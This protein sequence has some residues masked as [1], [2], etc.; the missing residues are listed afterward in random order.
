MINTTLRTLGLLLMGAAIVMATPPRDAHACDPEVIEEGWTLVN[1]FPADGDDAAPINGVVTARL[2]FA[3]HSLRWPNE[4]QEPNSLEMVLLRGADELVEGQVELRAD[5]KEARFI[6]ERPLAEGVSYTLRLTLKNSEVGARGP[7]Q[8]V[9]VSFTTGNLFDESPPAFSGIQSMRLTQ[10]DSPIKECCEGRERYCEGTCSNPCQWCWIAGWNYLP[11]VQLDFNAGEDEFGAQTVV[12]TVHRLDGPDAELPE[13]PL[14]LIRPG[15]AALQE[16]GRAFDVEDEGPFCFDVVAHDAFGRQSR[17]GARCVTLD[18]LEPIEAVEVPPEDRSECAD[19]DDN[20]EMDAGLT[21]DAGTSDDDAGSSPDAQDEDASEQQV[22]TP[23]S[24][25]SG[26]A[27]LSAPTR[28][29]PWGWLVVGLMALW[30]TR[31]RRS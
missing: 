9:E 11:L 12:Y 28:S 30:G 1:T 26:C 27:T 18:D 7:D 20:E 22:V 13:E 4:E 5:L 23:D 2:N 3:V 15:E 16:F 31:R 19:Q 25:D 8:V 17:A 14:A 21:P 24:N 10:T 6:S 29:R